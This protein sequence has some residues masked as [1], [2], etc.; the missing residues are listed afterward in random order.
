MYD[1][2]ESDYKSSSC[3]YSVFLLI[4]RSPFLVYSFSFILSSFF[5]LHPPLVDQVS[6][7]DPFPI[8]TFLKSLG[9]AVRL[10]ITVQVSLLH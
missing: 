10:K 6:G 2:F 5:H 8:S 7:L 3:C 1:S 4:F 9:V